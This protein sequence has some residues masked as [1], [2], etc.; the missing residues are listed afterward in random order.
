MAKSK[1]PSKKPK[2]NPQKFEQYLAMFLF[3]SFL[4]S[5]GVLL[6][7]NQD[8]SGKAEIG[9]PGTVIEREQE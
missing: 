6:V 2:I 9:E 3:M 5:A 7:R 8:S 1:K 4:L